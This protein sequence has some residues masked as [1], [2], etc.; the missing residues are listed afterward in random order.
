MTIKRVLEYSCIIEGGSGNK[1]TSMN[2]HE[3]LQAGEIPKKIY[4]TQTQTD[5]EGTLLSSNTVELGVHE[6]A[7]IGWWL[8]EM[9]KEG[10]I[11]ES[12]CCRES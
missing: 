9:Y 10:V 4:I 2:S 11:N 3:S 6:L 5:K 1:I 8:K 12:Y 7:R